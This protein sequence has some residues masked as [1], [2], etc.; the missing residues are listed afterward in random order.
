[1]SIGDKS[2]KYDRHVPLYRSNFI[3]PFR[4][5]PIFSISFALPRR[6]SPPKR[7]PNFV[8]TGDTLSNRFREKGG[9]ER[10]WKGTARIYR[11]GLSGIGVA[12]SDPRKPDEICTRAAS[13]G[14]F[15]FLRDYR[16]NKC[17]SVPYFRNGNVNK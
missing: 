3:S 9:R 17:R 12:D 15:G 6:R 1:M 7:E 10:G 2:R 8:R 11:R 5:P 4:R 13:R 14:L 16:Q